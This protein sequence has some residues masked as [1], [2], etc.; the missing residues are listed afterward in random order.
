MS[1]SSHAFVVS[2][3]DENIT[4]MQDIIQSVKNVT[5]LMIE[6]SLDLDHLLEVG[7]RV[8]KVTFPQHLPSKRRWFSSID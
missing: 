6:H 2:L 4:C 5:L 8:R 7:G 1:M 3:A